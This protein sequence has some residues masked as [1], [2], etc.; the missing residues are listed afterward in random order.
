MRRIL[1]MLLLAAC[2][3]AED[4]AALP[5]LCT[6]PLE[7]VKG[8][9]D[10]MALSPD[11]NRLAVAALGNDTIEIID[12]EEGR[13]LRSIRGIPEP[14]AGAFV[15]GQL[16]MAAAGDGNLHFFDDAWEHVRAVEIGS[17]ADPVRVDG[18][19]QYVGYGVGAI[20][21]VEKGAVLYTIKLDGHPEGFQLEA[22]GPRIFV[23]VP[24]AGHVA[25]CDRD[26]REVVATW[27][28]GDARDNYPLALDEENSRVLVG[29]RR[30][31]KLLVLDM[32]DGGVRRTV[33]ISGDVDDLFL[34]GKARR[35]YASCGEGF[36]DV[37]DADKY[38]RVARVPTS[39]GAR[40]CLLDTEGGRLFVAAPEQGKPAAI[41]IYRTTPAPARD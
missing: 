31:A 26:K 28:L 6:I 15:D 29:C 19:R 38:E 25:V 16:A 18:H 34:D 9:F 41:R 30:P 37:I 5:L 8:R 21:V 27:E 3:R 24:D 40:T 1:A 17:D 7:G 20:A 23:N 36:V 11:G 33:D 12:L 39:R 32:K 14:T 13:L 22:K 10:H 4:D 2:V 35:I